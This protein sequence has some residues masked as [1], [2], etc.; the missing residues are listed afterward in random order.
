MGLFDKLK[1]AFTKENGETPI[2]VEESAE[3]TGQEDEDGLS[4][5]APVSTEMATTSP[6]S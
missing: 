1:R 5:E 4:D 6:D 2:E 3:R